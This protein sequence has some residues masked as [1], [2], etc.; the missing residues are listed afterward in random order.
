[1]NVVQAGEFVAQ[2]TF[3]SCWIFTAAT[4][5]FWPWWQ[6]LLG[7]SIQLKTIAIGLALLP[8][9]LVI[10]LGPAYGHKPWLQWLS[11][12]A[13]ATIPLILALRVV[14]IYRYQRNGRERPLR[15]AVRHR[16]SC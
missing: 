6:T 1:M 15:G 13:V 12:G 16:D 2:A 14:V 10:W 5:V 4:S 7:W 9:M 3:W 8:S 11:I